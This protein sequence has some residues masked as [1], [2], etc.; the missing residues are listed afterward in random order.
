MVGSFRQNC[1]DSTSRRKC[2]HA[3]L[4]PFST[5]WHSR[6]GKKY[7]V[8]TAFGRTM[9][10]RISPTQSRQQ[11]RKSSGSFPHCLWN[12][13]HQ[14]TT[15]KRQAAASALF[16]VFFE[17]L[18]I[19]QHFRTLYTLVSRPSCS[20]GKHPTGTG[21]HRTEPHRGSLRGCMPLKNPEVYI[22]RAA[23]LDRC[24]ESGS[25]QQNR[26]RNFVPTLCEGVA[27]RY[28]LLHYPVSGCP[29]EL[30]PC[31]WGL[32]DKLTGCSFVSLRNLWSGHNSVPISRKKA[33]EQKSRLYTEI[34]IDTSTS[35]AE[36]HCVSSGSFPKEQAER[37]RGQH[38]A[39]LGR[40]YARLDCGACLAVRPITQK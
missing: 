18:N 15:H 27:F 8:I 23:A 34:H 7:C 6:Q 32:G 5:V 39:F 9:L 37:L 19:S 4:F 16:F 24:T 30:R 38:G 25:G 36:P 20:T 13:E 12:S 26:V 35:P 22:F 28:S 2:V 17:N 10:T 33:A 40:V 29:P 3:F 14:D 1:G 11:H 31:R 21:K